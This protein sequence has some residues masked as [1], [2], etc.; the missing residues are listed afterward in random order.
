MKTTTFTVQGRKQP[1]E[2]I[3]KKTLEIH[4]KYMKVKADKYYTEMPR[5]E[6]INQLKNLHEYNP[7]DVVTKM[8][9][10]L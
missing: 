4:E 1:L 9:K 7:E 10:K 3:R 5:E 2:E 6:V 8:K